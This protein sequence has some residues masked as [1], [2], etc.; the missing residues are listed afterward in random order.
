[1]ECFFGLKLYFLKQHYKSWLRSSGYGSDPRKNTGSAFRSINK[2]WIRHYKPGS[3]DLNV[4]KSKEENVIMM[5]NALT[6][7][8]VLN[9]NVLIHAGCRNLVEREPFV[10]QRHIELYV[11]VLQTGEEIHMNNVFSTN[12]L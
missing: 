5:M 4:A 3:Q 12:V 10:K 2:N 1:M 9:T 7:G 11:A 6:T 8:R